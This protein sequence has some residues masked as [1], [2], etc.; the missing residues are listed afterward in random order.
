MPMPHR[1]F[2]QGRGGCLAQWE[3]GLDQS[4]VSHVL[5]SGAASVWGDTPPPGIVSKTAVLRSP[6]EPISVS[7]LTPEASGAGIKPG[8][9]RRHGPLGTCRSRLAG[10]RQ[11]PRMPVP[12]DYQQRVKALRRNMGLK[13]LERAVANGVRWGASRNSPRS[14]AQKSLMP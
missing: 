7:S 13:Q 14:T 11:E 4:L 9:R 2:M 12:F 1:L 8:D 10:P 5:T 3:C 6:P